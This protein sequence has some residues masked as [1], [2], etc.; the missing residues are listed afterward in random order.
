LISSFALEDP[1]IWKGSELNGTHKFL[2][3]A[4]DVHILGGNINIME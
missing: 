3:Y 1:K 4:D 2:V